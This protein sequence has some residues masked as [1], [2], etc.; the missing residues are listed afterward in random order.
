MATAAKLPFR[1]AS[2]VKW[3]FFLGHQFSHA[4]ALD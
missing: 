4:L 3:K 2:I 1:F